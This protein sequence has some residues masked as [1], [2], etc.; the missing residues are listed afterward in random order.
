MFEESFRVERLLSILPYPS[1][2][3]VC[4]LLVILQ[5]GGGNARSNAVQPDIS[6]NALVSMDDTFR[7][8][9][10]RVASAAP[11]S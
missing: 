5:C 3:R 1:S 6:W 7:R 11:E 10:D 8:T 4:R 2:V 9:D